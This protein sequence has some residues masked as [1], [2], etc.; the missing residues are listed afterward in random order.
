MST[1]DESSREVLIAQYSAQKIRDLNDSQIILTAEETLMEIKLISGGYLP[2][3]AAYTKL[4]ELLVL[5]FKRDYKHLTFPEIRL[6]F[7]R[8]AKK[9]KIWGNDINL[10]YIQQILDFFSED[11]SEALAVQEKYAQQEYT[12]KKIDLIELE[13]TGR[14]NIEKAYQHFLKTGE[15]LL[16]SDF[17]YDQLVKDQYLAPD[18]YEESLSSAMQSMKRRYQKIIEDAKGRKNAKIHEANTKS[19]KE[20]AVAFMGGVA[21]MRDA[22]DKLFLLNCLEREMKAEAVRFAFNLLQKKN[23]AG[24]YG[25]QSEKK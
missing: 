3:G 7:T 20:E 21:D 16:V 5:A 13:N 18:L 25:L 10:N 17:D 24:L 1:A 22:Q 2:N 19:A 4:V 23:V 14:Q 11:R 9:V 15:Y 8:H 12:E 6:A